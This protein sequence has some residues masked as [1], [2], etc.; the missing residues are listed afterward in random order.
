MKIDSKGKR[1]I[2]VIL[3]FF[4]IFLIIGFTNNVLKSNHPSNIETIKDLR[5]SGSSARIHINN[6]WTEAKAAEICTGSGTY[7]DPYIIEDFIII[8]YPESGI[9]IENSN[10]YLIIRNCT[11]GHAGAYNGGIELVNVNNSQLI[12]NDCSAN[13]YGIKLE[14]CNN[15][16]VVGNKA[17]DSESYG[18]TLAI[19]IRLWDSNNNNI[20]GN[21]ANYS[22]HY[23]IAL[24]ESDNNLIAINVANECE[25]GDGIILIG[26][27]NNII[28][29]NTANRNGVMS[30]LNF[31]VR[32]DNGISLFGCEDSIIQNNIAN[33]N[34]QAGI[35]LCSSTGITITGNNVEL[36]DKGIWLDYFS[37]NNLIFT[38]EIYDNNQYGIYLTRKSNNNIIIKN[39]LSDNGICIEEI[40][41]SGNIYWDNGFCIYIGAPILEIIVCSSLATI[42]IITLIFLEI[43][44]RKT[45]KF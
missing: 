34:T 24:Y 21:I 27:K 26:C 30:F 40:D 11:I 42:G 3:G 35:Y 15:N 37:D 33:G 13:Y 41:C 29:G 38:S 45:H 23:G 22:G 18:Y 44:R 19:G 16:T 43:K 6:N 1:V 2:I 32:N 12:D 36:N 8:T 7:S 4:F 10:Y 9:L 39:H 25:S 20:T 5:N 31:G 17:S 14:N 28:S